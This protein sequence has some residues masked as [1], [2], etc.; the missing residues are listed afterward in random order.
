MDLPAVSNRP[1]G[2]LGRLLA[3]LSLLGRRAKAAAPLLLPRAWAGP[4][5]DAPA[6]PF[7]ISLMSGGR[8]SAA[9][10]SS[11]RGRAGDRR[12]PNPNQ[13]AYPGIFYPKTMLCSYKKVATCSLFPF[14]I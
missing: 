10:S 4:V 14:S 1:G 8:M 7:L 9:P 13:I 11:C 12:R 6:S 3:V 2:P 5:E